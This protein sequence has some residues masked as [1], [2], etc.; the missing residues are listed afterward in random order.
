[1]SQKKNINRRQFLSKVVGIS[2]GALA[3]PYFVPSS[4]LGKSSGVAA[5][6]RITLG[7]IGLGIRGGTHIRSFIE[8]DQAQIVAVCD[9]FK[10]RR[11]AKKKQI[12]DRYALSRGGGYKGCDTYSDFREMLA[13]KDIDA[14]VIGTP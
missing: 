8:Y 11:E 1:M 3:F 9:L 10:S 14:V 7:L 12:E 6:E 4:A 5:S 2:S 13:R